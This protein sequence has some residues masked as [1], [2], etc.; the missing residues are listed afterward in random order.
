M[1]YTK[2]LVC[3]ANSR[4]N[5]G[6]CVAGL[7]LTDDQL[8]DWIRPISDR[9]GEELSL[10]ER[11]YRNGDEVELLDIVDIAFK[12]AQPHGCQQENHLIDQTQRWVYAGSLPPKKLLPMATKTDP[13]WI[14]GHHSYSGV[15][16]RIPEKEADSLRSSLTLVGPRDLTFVVGMGRTKPQ[17]RAAFALGKTQYNVVVT[18]PL[19]E[20]KYLKRPDGRYKYDENVLLCISL[21]EP[22]EGYRYKLLAAVIAVP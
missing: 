2:R 9:P 17:V 4:K 7:E 13:L 8:G 12:R 15:N 16:D 20:S 11:S 21:G 5:K 19:V 10:R 14:E 18:D 6:T 22:Y 1:S 3:L